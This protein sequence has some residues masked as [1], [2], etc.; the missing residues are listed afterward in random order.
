MTAYER[1]VRNELTRW[2]QAMQKPP[3]SFGKLSTSLQR[4]INRIIPDR[5]HA[6]ITAT[7]KQMTRAVLFG[8]EFLN[9]APIEGQTLTQRDAAVAK[10]IDF[11]RKT[12]AAEGGVTGAGGF[13]LGLADFPILLALK[14]K[15]LF[16]IASLYGF[17][18]SDYRERVFILYVFQL[19]FS[20][21]ERRQL[22]YEYIANWPEHSRQLPED[23]NQFD[24]LTFQQEYRDYID[25][26][27]MA[28]LI[29]GIGAAVGIVVNYRLINQLGRTAM[30]A[31]RMR[32]LATDHPSLLT[33]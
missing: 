20:S 7:I 13:W 29:P 28:Q 15:M 24:W 23:I 22:V 16:E 2:Q 5:V 21:Q 30:N 27:K 6:I 31:Y 3:S 12:S 17:S 8:A 32:L 11:Y 14:M 25:L 19:A 4:R 33:E 18:V 10:R 9:K 1:A 26:A